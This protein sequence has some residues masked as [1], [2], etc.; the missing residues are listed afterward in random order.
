[1]DLSIL[2]CNLVQGYLEH[3]TLVKEKRT[4]RVWLHAEYIQ[5]ERRVKR[6]RTRHPHSKATKE[7]N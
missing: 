7:G 1:M 3:R 2:H 4:L 5:G 6:K